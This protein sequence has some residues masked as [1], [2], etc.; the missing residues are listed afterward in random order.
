MARGGAG[1]GSDVLEHLPVWGGMGER[2]WAQCSAG[3]FF[4]VFPGAL[5]QGLGWQRGNGDREVPW[6]GLRWGRVALG[7]HAPIP[8]PVPVP[9]RPLGR[10]CPTPAGLQV[11]L[12]AE[13][14][15]CLSPVASPT[16]G[17]MGRDVTGI[18]CEGWLRVPR[19]RVGFPGGAGVLIH[20]ISAGISTRRGR[21]E[22][23]ACSKPSWE[24]QP[25]PARRQIPALGKA[26]PRCVPVGAGPG[27]AQED[28]MGWDGVGTLTPATGSRETGIPL[29]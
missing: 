20:R 1:W 2:G 18:S 26:S 17:T 22:L 4:Q 24:A 29:L 27:W 25:S 11:W 16:A 28:G 10:L 12:G 5:E 8:V 23:P 13:Q 19:L 3:R 21:W 14:F 15:P 7:T 9:A 6:Q